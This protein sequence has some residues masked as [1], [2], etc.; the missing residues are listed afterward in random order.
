MHTFIRELIRYMCV[1]LFPLNYILSNQ[2][3]AFDSSATVYNFEVPVTHNYYVGKRVWIF[4]TG[5]EGIT[6][7]IGWR[8]S[9]SKSSWNY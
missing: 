7:N 4:D 3:Q 6:S 5:F 2:V 8:Q 1:F 9:L